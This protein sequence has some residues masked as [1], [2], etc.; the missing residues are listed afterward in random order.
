MIEGYFILLVYMYI[1]V[2]VSQA[3]ANAAASHKQKPAG[4][5]ELLAQIEA[6]M[7]NDKRQM[8]IIGK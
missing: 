7:E 2:I 8:E 5:Q 4:D 6:L 3:A 1:W